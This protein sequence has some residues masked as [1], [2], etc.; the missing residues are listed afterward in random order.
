MFEFVRAQR[1]VNQ[2]WT[3]QFVKWPHHP[4]SVELVTLALNAC[5][6][7]CHLRVV[8]IDCLTVEKPCRSICPKKQPWKTHVKSV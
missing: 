5:L 8:V 3:W 2:F 1:T 6:G 7:G 4:Y